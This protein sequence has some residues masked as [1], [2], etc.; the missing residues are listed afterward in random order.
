LG[1]FLSVDGRIRDTSNSI[2]RAHFKAIDQV[3]VGG[4]ATAALIDE[5]GCLVSPFLKNGIAGRVDG[6]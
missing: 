4:E 1:Y 2:E 5:Q 3:F 6:S